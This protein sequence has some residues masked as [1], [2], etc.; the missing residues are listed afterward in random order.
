MFTFNKQGIFLNLR[1]CDYAE[2]VDL[3]KE[4]KSQVC[5]AQQKMPES[6]F[7]LIII[8]RF[9]FKIKTHFQ[10]NKYF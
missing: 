1:Q 10:S 5:S 8:S 2:A 4:V 7:F 9:A 6:N 3:K